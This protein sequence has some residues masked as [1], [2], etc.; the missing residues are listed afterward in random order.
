MADVV[1]YGERVP[2]R[3]LVG[4]LNVFSVEGGGDKER[5]EELALEWN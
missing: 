5:I 3:G 2:G 4:K 1:R